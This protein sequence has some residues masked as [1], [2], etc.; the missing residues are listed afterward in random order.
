MPGASAEALDRV[1]ASDSA[2]TWQAF[3]HFI[4]TAWQPRRAALEARLGTLTRAAEWRQIAGIDADSILEERRLF[5]ASTAGGA[6]T[7]EATC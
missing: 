1:R 7:P 3:A 6:A 4:A 2:A 5:A